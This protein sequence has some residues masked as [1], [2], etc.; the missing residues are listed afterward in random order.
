MKEKLENLAIKIPVLKQ[1][2]VLEEPT[3]MSLVIPFLQILGYDVFNIDEIEPEFVSDFGTKK[4]EKVDYAIKKDGQPI[5]LIECKPINENLKIHG[6]QLFR[7]FTVTKAK[8]GILTNGETYEFYT[9]L[10]K[11]NI[12][13]EIPFFKINISDLNDSDIEQLRNFHK[14]FYNTENIYNKA[15][16]MKYMN[17]I[18]ETIRKDLENPSEEFIRYYTSKVYSGRNTD[19]T[20]EMFSSL[21]KDAYKKILNQNFDKKLKDIVSAEKLPE[22]ENDN[23]IETTGLELDSYFL[24]RSLLR[25]KFGDEIDRIK[26]KDTINYFNIFV[27]RPGSMLIRLYLNGSIKY[28]AFFEG[29]KELERIKIESLN[30]LY[31]YTDLI[32]ENFQK[33]FKK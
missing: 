31:K 27:D 20:L 33:L 13:D 3:K 18:V 23:K 4:G 24:I 1:K 8:Y 28:V 14:T 30:E 10:E 21:I 5:I 7:Y 32:A 17:S 11:Q 15:S 6:S 25:N 22:I 2:N 16:K 19:K 9:D 29:G 12:M 26:Y